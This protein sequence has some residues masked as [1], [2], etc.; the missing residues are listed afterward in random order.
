MV[1]FV[2]WCC[3]SAQNSGDVNFAKLRDLH[4]RDIDHLHIHQHTNIT[5]IPTSV[6]G[7][8]HLGALSIELL[9]LHHIIR[10]CYSFSFAS[11]SAS[12]QTLG[13]RCLVGASRVELSAQNILLMYRIIAA[14]SDDE[15][16]ASEDEI[17]F[18]NKPE[19]NKDES[20][21]KNNEEED[22]GDGGEEYAHLKHCKK[23]TA[24]V[25]L[26]ICR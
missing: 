21:D 2:W 25:D 20:A 18:R 3:G 6:A 14:I 4:L 10:D 15:V 9:R 26:K 7:Y 22:E 23:E 24:D 17:P 11:S 16:S 12:S 8:Y 5:A 1:G 19:Q 13:K